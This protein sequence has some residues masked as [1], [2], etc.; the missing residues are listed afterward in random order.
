MGGQIQP[1]TLPFFGLN[2]LWWGNILLIPGLI[3]AFV[4]LV[5]NRANFHSMAYFSYMA[6]FSAFMFMTK[7]HERYLLPAIIFIT[8]CTIFEKRHL[9]A[10]ILLSLCVF[11][12]QLYIYIYS[13]DNIYWIDRWDVFA[14][15]VAGLTL[16][17]YVMS[18]YN[19]YRLFIKKQT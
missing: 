9:F 12:N 3:Y 7:M 1:D 16:T 13:F 6:L 15:T 14:L 10:A 2:Y 17:V 4:C 19:G 5:K 11:L 18:V 8:L